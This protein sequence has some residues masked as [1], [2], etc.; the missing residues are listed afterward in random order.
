MLALRKRNLRGVSVRELLQAW[1]SGNSQGLIGITFDDGYKDFI[2]SALP[3][4]EQYGFSA[5]VFM[6]AGLLGRENDWE[7]WHEPRPRMELLTGTDL[8]EISGRGVEIGA[9]SMSHP[10]LPELDPASLESEVNHS[11]LLL[12]QVLDERVD[13]FCYP[14]GILDEASIQ[15]VREAG[16]TYACG[17][18]TQI[19]HS[20]YDLPRIPISEVDTPLRF[21][22]KLTI[23]SQ[24]RTVKEL[25][26]RALGKTE[27]V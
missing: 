24:Y 6:V 1:N 9:H 18:N 14:Y 3:I 11:R 4:L 26:L 15:A 27:G 23:H 5:T 20:V 13:G 22:A 2:Y 17:V 21:A 19:D 10:R 16:Y 7:H 12:S 8:C 25:Y